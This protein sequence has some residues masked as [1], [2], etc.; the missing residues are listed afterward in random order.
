MHISRKHGERY[1][2]GEAHKHESSA[3]AAAYK[4]TGVIGSSLIG[5]DWLLM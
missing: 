1:H 3:L 4:G 2:S 5:D